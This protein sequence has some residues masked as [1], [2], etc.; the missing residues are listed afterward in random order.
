MPRLGAHLSIA[1]G[2]PRAI[3][4]AEAAGCETL[5]I[6][7]KSAGQWRARPIPA[8]ES[9]EF[10]QRAAAT[11]VAPIFAHGSYLVNLAAADPHLRARSTAALGEELDRAEALGLAGLVLH[12]GSSA[13][14]EEDALAAV[15][16]ALGEL[17]AARPAGRTAILLEHTAGQGTNLGHR[18]EQL[19]AILARLG[20]PA[21]VG[22]CLDTCHL[23]AAGYDI[24]TEAGYQQTCERFATTVGFDRLRLL[25]LNDSK[26]PCGSRVDRHEHIGKGCIGLDGFRRVL[27]DP[28]F[29]ALPMVLETP[30]SDA[31]KPSA[32]VDP[33]DR[34]NLRTLRKLLTP[35]QTPPP[36]T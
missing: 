27:A 14:P 10:K 3:D 13:G 7:T 25:H 33:L 5:Q 8:A 22:V 26:R 24:S 20:W 23:I 29:A 1:G 31:W 18:F 15:A 21:R 2:F 4:R 12:P 28:R 35:P 19:A 30:K 36:R 9:A 34:R 32:R 16:E 6:F 11:A 17:L